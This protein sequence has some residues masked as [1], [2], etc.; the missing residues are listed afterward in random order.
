[1]VDHGMN[2]FALWAFGDAHVGTDGGFSRRSQRG[3]CGCPGDYWF[4]HGWAS[5]QLIARKYA[6]EGFRAKVGE[7]DTASFSCSWWRERRL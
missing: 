6:G 5:D 7:M 3:R 1:M 4:L 2:T